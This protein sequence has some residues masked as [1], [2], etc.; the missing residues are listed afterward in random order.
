MGVKQLTSLSA[1][2]TIETTDNE[3]IYALNHAPEQDIYLRYQLTKLK[4][5]SLSPLVVGTMLPIFDSKFIHWPGITSL[6][7]PF[8]SMSDEDEKFSIV[9]RG[10]IFSRKAAITIKF[11]SKR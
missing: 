1:N 2:T 9:V 6:I 11:A 8:N 10:T 7:L 3:L 4:N 5:S